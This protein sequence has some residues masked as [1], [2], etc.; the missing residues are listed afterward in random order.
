M[1]HSRAF[2]LV[3][4]L[5]MLGII[6]ILAAMLLPSLEQSLEQARRLGCMNQL[7]QTYLGAAQYAAD[8]TGWL[9]APASGN[10]YSAA[11]ALDLSM[12]NFRDAMGNHTG[13]WALLEDAL[14]YVDRT[15]VRCPA[16]PAHPWQSG[17]IAPRYLVDYSYRYNNTDPQ[18]WFPAG[19]PVYGKNALAM[20]KAE[21][22]PLFYEAEAYRRIGVDAFAPAQQQPSATYRMWPHRDGGNLIAHAG[23][24]FWLDNVYVPGSEGNGYKLS[25]PSG[26]FITEIRGA[27]APATS[28]D[29][30]CENR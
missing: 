27:Y 6:S 21:V 28:L 4:L 25:W 22:R 18:R 10:W 13:W 12:P 15:A 5:I 14:G 30:F 1:P 24:V 23:N 2:S 16:S 11:S 7:R 9:P 3:E 29:V 8:R 19:Y 26:T 20:P 17:A